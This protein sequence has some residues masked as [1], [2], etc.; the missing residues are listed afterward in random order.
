MG[1]DSSYQSIPPG[2]AHECECP[3]HFKRQTF[4]CSR[5]TL[6]RERGR[7]REDVLIEVNSHSCEKSRCIYQQIW[8]LPVILELDTTSIYE[9]DFLPLMLFT[10]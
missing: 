5:R 9:E 7:E 1:Y 3:P 4:P 8:C 10:G 2:L 6:L